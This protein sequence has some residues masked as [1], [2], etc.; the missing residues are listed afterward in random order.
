MIRIA[1]M[2]ADP[3]SLAREWQVNHVQQEIL[4]RMARGPEVFDYPAADFLRFEL[5]LRGQIVISAQQLYRSGLAFATFEETRCHLTYWE[6]TDFGGCQLRPQVPPSVA[7]EDIFRNGRSYAL[8]CATAMVIILYH[9]VM[10]TI[11][12][13]D[14]DRMFQNLLLY[15]WRYDPDLQL[16]TAPTQTFL[17]GDILYFDNPD[18][19]PETPEWQGENAVFLGNGLYYGHGVGIHDAEGIIRHLNDRRR[20]GALRT[21]HLLNQATRP[22]FGYLAQFEDPSAH[23]RLIGGAGPAYEELI[24]AEIGLMAWEG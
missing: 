7:I 22:G 21:A 19:L 12:R 11:R 14:F 20:P 17:P 9:A 23:A 3:A 2:P 18:H 4:Q 13:S 5:R 1:G 16:T 24:R 15:D 10:Q 6:R 8:E